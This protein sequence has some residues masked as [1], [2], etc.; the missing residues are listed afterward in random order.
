MKNAT[1]IQHQ[2]ISLGALIRGVLIT[3]FLLTAYPAYSA[4]INVTSTV[5]V[6][7]DD[8]V[9]TLREAVIAANENISS[10]VLMGEC[11]GGSLGL[12]S[13]ILTQPETYSFSLLGSGEDAAQTGDLDITEDLNIEGSDAATFIISAGYLDRVFHIVGRDTNVVIRNLTL[14]R[15][16]RTD[17]AG[18]GIYNEG[19]LSVEDSIITHNQVGGYYGFG[20]GIYNKGNSLT[21]TR[22]T[23][24]NNLT[25][26]RGS[27]GGGY[28]LA[29]EL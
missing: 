11:P 9:C 16:Q 25:Y 29:A 1:T 18:G 22:T 13:V 5:D 23:L 15:G 2:H 24:R 21:L 17:A 7:A 19:N 27:G 28:I 26:G 3:L 12:D 8:G 10:G 14:S 6:L 4:T 20:G